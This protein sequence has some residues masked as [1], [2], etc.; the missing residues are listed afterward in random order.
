MGLCGALQTC[1]A[2]L[3]AG[4][5]FHSYHGCETIGFQGYCRVGEREG[6]ELGELKHM[7]GHILTQMQ[8]F[9]FN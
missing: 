6:W 1:S 7:K 4:I 3:H 9:F 5:G 2:L 8:K